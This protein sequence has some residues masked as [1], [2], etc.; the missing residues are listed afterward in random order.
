VVGLEGEIVG[1]GGVGVGAGDMKGKMRFGGVGGG[2]L[3]CL[4]EGKD[5]E[6]EGM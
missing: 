2:N 3:R 5:V 1:D 4:V 6:G